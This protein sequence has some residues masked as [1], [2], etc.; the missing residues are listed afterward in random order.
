MILI[1]LVICYLIVD[2]QEFSE[3]SFFL[4][5]QEI[6]VLLQNFKFHDYTR[7]RV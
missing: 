6:Y 4:L 3:Y 2:L 1:T 7:K 5:N